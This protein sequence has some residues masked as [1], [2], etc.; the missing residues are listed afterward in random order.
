[1]SM[2]AVRPGAAVVAA[3]LVTLLAGCADPPDSG[4]FGY[5]GEEYGGATPDAEEVF[6]DR[7]DGATDAG[8]P[9][10]VAELTGFSWDA[11]YVF[12]EGVGRCEVNA[13]VVGDEEAMERDWVYDGTLMVFTEGGRVV[14][15]YHT[16]MEVTGIGR[17]TLFSPE[18]ELEGSTLR[19]P[20]P[21]AEQPDRAAARA[22]CGA[23][24]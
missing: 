17:Q 9:V 5:S 6:T 8:E 2:R 7:L 21:P 20:A 15:S 3:V 13:V 23:G 22:G 14:G 12:L 24:D 18:T 11:L 19:D 16:Y 10:A 1:M 4:S